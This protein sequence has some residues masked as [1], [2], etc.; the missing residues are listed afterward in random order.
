[1]ASPITSERVTLAGGRCIIDI[2][3]QT[4]DSGQPRFTARMSLVDVDGRVVRPLV[5]PDG[6]TIKIHATSER[7]AV[8]VATSYLEGRFGRVQ[9]PEPVTSLGG[10]TVGSPYIAR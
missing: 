8:R 2:E 5:G 9:P 1:M 6:R 4:S 10:A 3:P 7:L